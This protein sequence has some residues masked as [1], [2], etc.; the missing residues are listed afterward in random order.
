MH[1]HALTCGAKANARRAGFPLL[2]AAVVAL[3]A[4]C[5]TAGA[6]GTAHTAASVAPGIVPQNR[7]ERL[8]LTLSDWT[9]QPDM[10]CVLQERPLELPD[11]SA[12]LDVDELQGDLDQMWEALDRPRGFVLMSVAYSGTGRPDDF[13]IVET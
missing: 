9:P 5:A 8:E 10:R 4:G 3:L 6:S 7:Q 13:H 1:V 12:L 11:A 2:G